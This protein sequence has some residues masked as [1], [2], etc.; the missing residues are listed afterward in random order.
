M[1]ASP[2]ARVQVGLLLCSYAALAAM[3]LVDNTR[4]PLFGDILK[5]LEL[6]DSLGS[7][8]FAVASLGVAIGSLLTGRLARAIGSVRAMQAALLG[9]SAGFVMIALTPDLTILVVGS[10]VFGVGFGGTAVCQNV[11]IE[12]SCP[13][14]L[15]RRGFAGLHAT[16]GIASLSSPLAVVLLTRSGAD[17][18]AAFLVVAIVPAAVALS[19]F[20]VQR[21]PRRKALQAKGSAPTRRLDL[22]LIALATG[23]C[24]VA[25]IGLA[26]RL[27]LLL[28]RE[29]WT[30]DRAK[31][32]L[33]LFFF[34]MLVGRLVVT[35][36]PLRGIS[37]R[38]L[39]ALCSASGGIVFLVGLSSAPAV[40]P[41]VGLCVGPF[42]PVAMDLLTEEFPDGLESAIG[43]VMASLSV[44][45]VCAH[46]AIGLLSDE[47]GLRAA[48]LIGPAG[49]LASLLLLAWSGAR[50][51][52]RAG[53]AS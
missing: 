31:V 1:T 37:N 42:F 12:E 20:A 25:E 26:T 34:G 35:I 40:L 28:E 29:A 46:T 4:G 9:I 19:A 17:W 10:L 16:Y 38:A 21:P 44:L 2:P 22:A 15:R 36:L 11:M 47:F 18:R 33:S 48:L 7:P 8:M 32:W 14:E 53:P 41:L 24:V 39:L 43:I 50:P 45:L 3:G 5:E 27:P 52:N 23:G 49:L 13:P 51:A 30:P 6:S